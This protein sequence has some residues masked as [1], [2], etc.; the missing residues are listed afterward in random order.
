MRSTADRT[1]APMPQEPRLPETKGACQKILRQFGHTG[2]K[3]ESI[4]QPNPR[5]SA[6]TGRVFA[7]SQPIYS[8]PG[9]WRRKACTIVFSFNAD[10]VQ[11]EE[12][13]GW[14]I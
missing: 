3:I 10:G 4:E 9:R 11:T 12:V 7:L 5:A 13:D 8:G 14:V 6:P 2:L 1:D